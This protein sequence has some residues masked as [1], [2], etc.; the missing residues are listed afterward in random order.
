MPD[1]AARA[2]GLYGL[3]GVTVRGN[4]FQGITGS[5]IIQHM[6][7]LRRD[8]S[9]TAATPTTA[10]PQASV[11]QRPGQLDEP[12]RLGRRRS[13]RT[14]PRPGVAFPDPTRTLASYDAALGG[15]GVDG[16]VLGRRPLPVRARTGSRSVHRRGGRLLPARRLRHGGLD[17]GASRPSV[18]SAQVTDGQ[19]VGQANGSASQ[20]SQ[21]RQLV[22]RFDQPVIP[23]PNAFSLQRLNTGGSGAERQFRRDRRLV[24]PR[25]AAAILVVTA[26]PG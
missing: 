5:H 4:A 10:R 8:R 24:R 19:A 15:G 12:G 11:V 9:S 2:S 23:A 16:G 3:N 21:V 26:R 22:V 14:P 1:L 18:V 13:S 6:G 7:P 20:R 17:A 25:G